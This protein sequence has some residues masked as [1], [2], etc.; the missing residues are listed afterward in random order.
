MIEAANRR[1]DRIVLVVMLGLT[2]LFVAFWV[3]ELIEVARNRDRLAFTIGGDYAL[4]I[5]AARDWLAEGTFYHTR[6]LAGPYM[7]TDGDVLYPPTALLLF[8]PFT[9]L[10]SLAWWI[11]PL[12]I[13]ACV[14]A[15]HRPR[16]FAWP[17]LAFCLWW[18]T[19][20]IK[21]LTGNPVIWVQAAV[22]LGTIW[23]AFA[24]GALLKPSL[25]PFA[26]WGIRHRSWWLGVA[27]F[28]FLS[29]FFLPLWQQYV[30]VILDSRN[31][32]G[33]GYSLGEVPLLAMPLLAWAA[34]PVRSPR[35]RE[36]GHP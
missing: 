7:V 13:T 34:G 35:P 15:Y 16:P 9:A 27:V 31:P 3:G 26:L 24:V 11:V 18:S 28:A 23:P 21:I 22:S 25:G 8:V 12:G 14:I 17:A 20:T 1:R 33:V 29:L 32:S 36:I 30:R 10:P 19:S 2:F 5:G 6:Q 4:Y